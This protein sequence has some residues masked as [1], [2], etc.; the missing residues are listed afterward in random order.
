MEQERKIL[1]T[2]DDGITAD[3]IIRLA[4]AAR[5]YGQVW[6]VAPE[7]QRSA[8]SHSITLRSHIDIWKHEFPV[9]GVE[10]Y[11]CSGTPGDCVRVGALNIVPGKPDIVFSGINYGYNC[12]SDI[13]YSATVGA[14]L[15]AAFQEIPAIAFSEGTK[16]H[17]VTDAYLEQI[18]DKLIDKKLPAETIWNVNFPDCPL[19][20]LAGIL[21]ERTMSRKV[22]FS[23]SYTE[24]QL[25]SGIR[26]FMVHGQLR[27]DAEPGSDYRA[28][29]DNYI[30]IGQV[31]NLQAPSCSK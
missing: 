13:Q 30:S 16:Y 14:A 22:V 31:E 1:I 2:N 6:V 10:A 27:E 7:S 4:K 17:E 15:E 24:E 25:I 12:A 3:G 29:L 5:K 11:A 26:R 18:I 19:S 28:L 9:E 20:Q 21:E 23:D 8:M